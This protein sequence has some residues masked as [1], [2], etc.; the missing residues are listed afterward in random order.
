[1]TRSIWASALIISILTK[2]ICSSESFFSYEIQIGDT[3]SGIA[4]RF[5]V[6]QAQLI[7]FLIVLIGVSGIIYLYKYKKV[8]H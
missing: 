7:A 3:L 8:I 5:G 6:T 2:H 1:M 4:Q